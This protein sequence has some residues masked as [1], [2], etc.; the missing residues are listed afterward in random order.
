M[1]ICKTMGSN[2][3]F[4][5]K[6]A[7]PIVA[8]GSAIA[9]ISAFTI[10]GKRQENAV[11]V[12]PYHFHA[13][14]AF[15]SN[16]FPSAFIHKFLKFGNGGHTPSTTPRG[17]DNVVTSATDVTADV[18]AAAGRF[19]IFYIHLR[20]NRTLLPFRPNCNNLLCFEIMKC[21]NYDLPTSRLVQGR[22]P[23]R[24]RRRKLTGKHGPSG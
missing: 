1:Q 11:A 6:R 12:R 17:A 22:L 3:R 16:P 24:R 20:R 18:G 19:R 8:I 7:A 2:T 10:T 14:N 5:V 9:Q 4:T 23:H 21:Q 13:F 15:E